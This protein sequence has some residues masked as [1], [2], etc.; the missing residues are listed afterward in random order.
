MDEATSFYLCRLSQIG[1]LRMFTTQGAMGDDVMT[2]AEA[3]RAL[4]R[5]TAYWDGVM[6]EEP[7]RLEE[8]FRKATMR[9]EVSPK[10]WAD[11]YLGTF[12]QG[13][14]LN[15]VTF[16]KALAGRVENSILLRA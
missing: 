4:D 3:W 1:V 12:V 10:H 7:I 2:Q 11:A 9:D 14:H 8:S 5:L 15:L 6:L 16:D 13:H